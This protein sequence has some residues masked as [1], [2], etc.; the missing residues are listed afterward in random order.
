M[1][2]REWPTE[3]VEVGNGV[4]AYIQATGGFCISNAGFIVGDE[5]VL[6]VDT[7]FTPA[8][9][10]EFQS[11]MRRVTSLPA[12]RLINTHHH[13]DH[14]LGNPFFP[15]SRIISHCAAC[16]EMEKTEIGLLDTIVGMAPHFAD[17]LEGASLRS[18]DETFE[19]SMELRLDNRLVQLLCFGPAH[20]AGDIA[21]Y[22]PDER[23]LFA[24]DL[25]FFWVTPVSFDGFPAKW[26][27]V[28]DQ[29]LALDVDR[30]VPGH[31]PVGGMDDMRLVRDYLTLL[32][33]QAKAGYDAGLSEGDATRRLNLG[34]FASWNEPERAR[35][36][37]HR[38]YQE[39]SA[40]A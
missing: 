13:I 26:A 20:T 5:E 3:L 31:G 22:L 30:I 16:E 8:M 33:D 39:F 15:E 35:F 27:D 40:P 9:N 28:C 23:L 21:A 10:R 34:D 29:L 38:L 17:Q 36:N 2:A 7:L 11:Q 4:F 37:V 18:A 24:G 14:T 12:R 25:A 1:S 19:G 6:V 32:R